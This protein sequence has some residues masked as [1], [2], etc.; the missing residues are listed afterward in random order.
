M[1]D[2][3]VERHDPLRVHARRIGAVH[4]DE[5]ELRL[6]HVDRLVLAAIG[7][8]D[9][10][11]V[12][13]VER[14]ERLHARGDRRFLVVGWREDADRG[15]QARADDDVVVDADGLVARAPHLEHRRHEQ[16]GVADVDEHEVGEDGGLDRPHEGLDGDG[17]RVAHAVAPIAERSSA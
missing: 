8:D 3:A 9:D 11:E 2:G 10:F 12:R 13:V 15:R 17:Q 1:L 5:R 7:D 6:E 4:L 16:A 14:E